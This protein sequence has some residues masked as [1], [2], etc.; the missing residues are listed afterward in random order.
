MRPKSDDAKKCGMGRHIQ[1]MTCRAQDS[2]LGCIAVEWPYIS[3]HWLH[4][5][6]L[7]FLAQMGVETMN[8]SPLVGALFLGLQ[9]VLSQEEDLLV[10]EP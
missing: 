6:F 10:R 5:P 2:C 1:D 4:G 7:T 9:A 3:Q 8:S